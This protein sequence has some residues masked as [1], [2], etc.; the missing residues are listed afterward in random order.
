MN[1]IKTLVNN[2][3]KHSAKPEWAPLFDEIWAEHI[4]RIADL[5]GMPYEELALFVE[6]SEIHDPIFG[7]IFEDFATRELEEDPPNFAL[8]YLKQR[9]WRETPRARKYLEA[10]AHSHPSLYEVLEVK[11]DEGLRLKDLLHPGEPVWVKEKAATHG[12]HPWDLLFARV[13]HPEGEPQPVLTGGILRFPRESGEQLL[14]SLRNLE[15]VVLE[16][17]SSPEDQAIVLTTMAVAF[18]ITS[19]LERMG[20]LLD[21]INHDGDPVAQCRAIIPLRAHPAAV[22]EK[23]DAAP[24]WH[25]A[26]Q[27]ERLW[28]LLRKKPRSPNTGIVMDTLVGKNHILVASLYLEDRHLRLETNSENRLNEALEAIKLALP[29]TFLGKPKITCQPMVELAMRGH[30]KGPRLPKDEAPAPV[31]EELAQATDYAKDWLDD[32]YRRTLRERIPSL[33]NKTPR[34]ALRSKKGR[35]QVIEWLKLIENASKAQGYDASWMWEE[36]GLGEERRALMQ[37]SAEPQ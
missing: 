32:H 23:L 24:F 9:G 15:E 6:T 4:E 34:M 18:T 11:R 12:L 26:P 21:A 27:G 17:Q 2:L 20:R 28:D 1:D 25:R 37:G 14:E 16:Q 29:K 3:T 7:A 19:A 5:L 35:Q 8:S 10:L 22:E 36:L 13:V 33:G 30:Q 31:P